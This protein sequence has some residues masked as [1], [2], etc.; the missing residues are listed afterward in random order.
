[1]LAPQLAGQQANAIQQLGQTLMQQ[2]NM[3][4]QAAGGLLGLLTSGV[5]PG[6]QLTQA[7]APV[8]LP[9]SKGT[10]HPVRVIRW[11]FLLQ[12]LAR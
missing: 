9:S 4:Q 11:R 8:G 2:Y 10:E 5:G 1:M 6:T 7:T 12:R 3:P